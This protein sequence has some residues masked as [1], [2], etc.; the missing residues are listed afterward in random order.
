MPQTIT[1]QITVKGIILLLVALAAVWLLVKFGG[2]LLLLFLAALLAVAITPL[3]ERLEAGMPRWVAIVLVYLGILAVAGAAISL[4]VPVL[5]E[6]LSQLG[7][8]LPQIT[9]RL[10]DLPQHWI[11]TYFPALGRIASD[12]PQQLSSDAGA[13]AGGIGTLLVTLGRTLT[14][15]LI[16]FLL[17]LVVAFFLTSDAHFAPR[18]IARF[19]PPNY[20]PI[21]SELAHRVGR[22]LGH[23]VRA[24]LLVGLFFG[25]A[26]G[27]GLA[28]LGVPYAFSLG[29]AGA[30]LELIP[31]VGG[32]IVTVVA[33]LVA[34]SISP[35]LALGVLVVEIAVATIESHI[36]YPKLVGNIV[37]LHPL[38]TIVALFVGAEARGV[39]G[40]LLA[41]P[42]A[43][44]LQ[45]LFE[46]FYRFEEALPAAT[47]DLTIVTP[48]VTVVKNQSQN[49]PPKTAP[50][51]A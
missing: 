44:V 12:L 7:E 40:A 14:T 33:M 5:V 46:H 32:L 31:Y 43:I 17:V 26:F 22:Q 2:I 3:V 25:V 6:E 29:V 48:A 24:Q 50:P 30:I 45:V 28:L 11:S 35:W 49:P 34:L 41:V 13:L 23:W 47:E 8:S 9:Q 16:N 18:F 4:L 21:T 20:R 15:I 1:I 51:R 39:V 37:G 38:T 36:V 27:L 42:V 19:F 10:L